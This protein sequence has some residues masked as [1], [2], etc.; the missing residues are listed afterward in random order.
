[1][2]NQ[3]L[4]DAHVHEIETAI[5]DMVVQAMG[6]PEAEAI[7]LRREALSR[8]RDTLGEQDR[9]LAHMLGQHE[10]KVHFAECEL[11]ARCGDFAPPEEPRP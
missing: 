2:S 8:L 5:R 7:A 4:L 6:K 11:E 9:A 10:P 3:Q 1:M